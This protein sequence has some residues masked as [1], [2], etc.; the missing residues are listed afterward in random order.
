M[1]TPGGAGQ[2]ENKRPALYMYSLY[3]RMETKIREMLERER[4]GVG[5]RR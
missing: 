5:F 3:R 4:G 2:E 1:D